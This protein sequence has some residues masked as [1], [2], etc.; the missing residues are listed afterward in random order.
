MPKARGCFL[1]PRSRALGFQNWVT[2]VAGPTSLAVG[3]SYSFAG[4]GYNGLGQAMGGSGWWMS[5]A[6][7]IAT[8]A[9]LTGSV[10]ALTA[11]AVTIMSSWFDRDG[12]ARPALVDDPPAST[13]NVWYYDP[14]NGNDGWDATVPAFVSGTTGP[15][16]TLF[17]T[18]SG[19]GSNSSASDTFAS[20][21]SG[22]I[23]ELVG[24]A[25]TYIP[26][27]S[28]YTGKAGVRYRST[29]GTRTIVRGGT[30]LNSMT[31]VLV[32]GNLWK[33]NAGQFR[34]V[35]SLSKER[36]WIAKK[37]YIRD[38][39][40]P[41]VN[42]HFWNDDVNHVLYV[43]TEDGATPARADSWFSGDADTSCRW[44]NGTVYEDI[45][46]GG[47]S[48]SIRAAAAGSSGNPNVGYFLRCKCLH[49][50]RR[51]ISITQ[52]WC[53]L[54]LKSFEGGYIGFVDP[55]FN[56]AAGGTGDWYNATLGAFDTTSF[57]I[58][59]Q[60]DNVNIR[61]D[62]YWLH[63]FINNGTGFQP[64]TDLSGTWYSRYG[65]IEYGGKGGLGLGNTTPK[66]PASFYFGYTQV[67]YVC[68][69]GTDESGLHT[70]TPNGTTEWNWYHHCGAMG[71]S[72]SSG[73][74]RTNA[75]TTWGNGMQFDT[76]SDNCTC[77]YSLATD[78][79]LGGFT[80]IESDA[81]VFKGCTSEGNKYNMANPGAPNSV[82]CAGVT[83]TNCIMH[84][85]VATNGTAR[86]LYVIWT[87]SP[88]LNFNQYSASPVIRWNGTGNGG[89]GHGAGTPTNYTSLASFQG[90]TGSP[91]GN[92]ISADPIW[93]DP[94]FRLTA[95][96]SPG[97][98]KG[99][100]YSDNDGAVRG[101][102]VD[103][104]WV[105]ESSFG[106]LTVTAA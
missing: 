50:E 16:K 88:V 42:R 1:W 28:G 54:T 49:V 72:V 95:A 74:N 35:T 56:T 96:N 19:A 10:A 73:S 79:I 69:D 106:S 93:K 29:P 86:D 18:A 84:A 76:N 2:Q 30:D 51:W 61:V 65:L 13:G 85:P 57:G 89:D 64:A 81:C 4:T 78:S 104:G 58:W 9:P 48:D 23:V 22:D 92:S 3:T 90:A 63:H 82:A 15:K 80:W 31:W 20:I 101:A 99:L 11:G 45:T 46:F 47:G 87:T 77:T 100:S 53:N 26:T 32:S 67:R 83:L 98:G 41:T 21:V 8:V 70:F 52:N 14:V 59:N 97:V 40:Q 60:A 37:M 25:T 34:T 103:I 39:A 71:G 66:G 27:S 24:G 38:T 43:Q 55:F 6:P 33:T 105:E 68:R 75:D 12:N 7:E 102:K 5:S 44:N 36:V 62:D 91:D 17:G 94:I